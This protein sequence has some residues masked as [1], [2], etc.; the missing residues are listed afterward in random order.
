MQNY[1]T[2]LLL[3]ILLKQALQSSSFGNSFII[4]ST[5][6]PLNSYISTVFTYTKNIE[7]KLIGQKL[8][9]LIYKHGIMHF[10]Y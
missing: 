10:T 2:D 5:F 7:F 1:L 6:Y 8:L 3:L 9:F 4:L